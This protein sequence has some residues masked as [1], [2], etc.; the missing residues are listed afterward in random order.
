MGPCMALKSVALIAL[1]AVALTGC[2]KLVQRVAPSL[3]KTE[4]AAPVDLDRVP[5]DQI[6]KAGQSVI[7]VKVPSRGLDTLLVVRDQKAGVT[8]WMTGDGN[9]FTFRDGLLI[10][11][12]GL[13]Y[14]LMS[15]AAPS[16]AAVLAGAG[17][18]NRSYF[19]LAKDDQNLRRDY[20][21]S[22]QDLGPAAVTLQGQSYQTRHF[23]ERCE[24]REGFQI[25][26][27]YWL[28]GDMIRRSKQ[29]AGPEIGMIEF[30]RIVD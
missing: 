26:N 3:A 7:R 18:H 22:S 4:Q 13:G 5:L 25:T 21:C 6:A 9:L 29:W 15:S 10:E 27:E 20:S 19:Y 28:D 16:R 24:R 1:T 12:R 23:A 8:S 30:Q 2:N 14:D 11:T 17:G